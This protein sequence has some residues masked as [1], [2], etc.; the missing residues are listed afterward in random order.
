MWGYSMNTHFHLIMELCSDT[1]L[2]GLKLLKTA[3][4][5]LGRYIST[6]DEKRNGNST[7]FCFN[8]SFFKYM[9][10]NFCILR[11]S[12]N[13]ENDSGIINKSS[14]LFHGFL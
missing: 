5:M 6:H 11:Y 8:K 9:Y 1:S 2:L 4:S 3:Q 12:F 10:I 13:I 7:I 14:R